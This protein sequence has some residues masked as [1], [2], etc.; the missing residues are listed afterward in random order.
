MENMYSMNEQLTM[1]DI[2]LHDVWMMKCGTI[3]QIT[4]LRGGYT[5]KPFQVRRAGSLHNWAMNFHRLDYK[6]SKG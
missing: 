3:V 1:D 2:K 4:V 6:I 5:D